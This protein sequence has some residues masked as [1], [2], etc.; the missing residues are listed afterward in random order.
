MNIK[1]YYIHGLNSSKKSGK[2]LSFSGNEE[3][4][5]IE[6]LEW[7]SN[8]NLTEKISFWSEVINKTYNEYDRVVIVGD[9]FGA[10]LACQVKDSLWETN[11]EYVSL[12]LINPLFDIPY[13]I[14]KEIIPNHLKNYIVPKTRITESLVFISHNDEVINNIQFLVDNPFIKNNNQIVLDLE[15]DHKFSGIDKYF[16]VVSGFVNNIYL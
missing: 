7:F 9:S 2:F 4:Q 10:N 16:E 14:N 6:C 15:N 13:V 12:V 3:F 8:E 11:K 5:N 1:Y